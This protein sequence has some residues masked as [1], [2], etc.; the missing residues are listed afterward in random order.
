MRLTVDIEA[1]KNTRHVD[2]VLAAS[3]KSEVKPQHWD[4]TS[5]VPSRLWPHAVCY[6]CQ[7]A[8]TESVWISDGGKSEGEES[9]GGVGELDGGCMSLLGELA[10]KEFHLCGRCL[11][12][13]LLLGFCD[14]LLP[15]SLVAGWV[16][17]LSVSDDSSMYAKFSP[18]K[19]RGC[20][21]GEDAVMLWGE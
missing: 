6:D 9:G 16:P 8:E 15:S 20:K 4:L 3:W 14:R 10:C 18:K 1:S 17:S 2:L 12:M 11:L 19:S 21:P 13:L 5:C 7:R